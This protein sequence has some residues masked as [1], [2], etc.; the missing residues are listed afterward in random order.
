M[1]VII[2]NKAKLVPQCFNQEEGI[3]YNETFGP[4]VR[5]E[6]IRMVLAFACFKDFVLHQMDVKSV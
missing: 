2:R 3:G 6:A 4:V 5:L 1:D